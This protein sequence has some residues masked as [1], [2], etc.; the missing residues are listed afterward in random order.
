MLS[1]QLLRANLIKYVT[2]FANRST[3]AR[4]ILFELPLYDRCNLKWTKRSFPLR[5][6]T[7]D[8]GKHG[9]V[10]VKPNLLIF[11]VLQGMGIFFL[12]YAPHSLDEWAL[13]NGLYRW[14]V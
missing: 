4:E 1:E 11:K 8:I 7:G 2:V 14:S 13:Q 12:D 5:R 3:K 9:H 10:I 6:L